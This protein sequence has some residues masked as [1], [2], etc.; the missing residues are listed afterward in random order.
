[1]QSLRIRE[2]P[3][4]KSSTAFGLA[5]LLRA[6]SIPPETQ[7]RDRGRAGV[8]SFDRA[9]E[10]LRLYVGSFERAAPKRQRYG[11]AA[12]RFRLAGAGGAV[13]GDSDR[14]GVRCSELEREQ[15][16]QRKLDIRNHFGDRTIH[17]AANDAP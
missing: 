8:R 5:R 12:K 6:S 7:S 1:M 9:P 13:Y 17:S 11:I 15:R 16:R 3:S 2:L 4:A 14:G 10:R